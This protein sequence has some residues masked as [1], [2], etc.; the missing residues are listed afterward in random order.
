[1]A[2]V[3]GAY[4][5]MSDF[6]KALKYTYLPRMLS[7]INVARPLLKRIRRDSN[8]ID[9]TGRSS[10]VPVNIL[11]SQALGA[12]ADGGALPAAQ[13]QRYT[14]MI[15][16]HRYNYGRIRL[17]HPTIMASRR[18]STSFI[19]VVSS[20]MDGMRRD[21]MNDINRQLFSDGSGALGFVDGSAGDGVLSI[22]LIAGH[23]CKPNMLVDS[24]TT[25][26]NGAA[27][28][29]NVDSKKIA[30]VSG[31]TITLSAATGDTVDDE[32]W[33]FREDAAGLE[34]M[35][36]LGICDG[37]TSPSYITTLHNIS[38][39]TYPDWGAQVIALG[40]AMTTT[41]M[42]RILMECRA[43]GEGNPTM[44]ITHPTTWRLIGEKLTAV[45]RYTPEQTLHGG[46]Q[47]IDWAGV[48]VF[49]DVQCPKHFAGKDNLF[50]LDES[51][52]ALFQMA[53]WD[54]IDDDGTIL[55]W[56]SGY[57]AFDATLFYYAN[58]GC[59]NPR[60]NGVLRSINTS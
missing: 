34:M 29:L 55:K 37:G 32:S 7:T 58:L 47:V 59:T 5:N 20:E 3:S 36:L 4:Q 22:T 48:P 26:A 33:I 41:A 38:R 57:A 31:T 17:T 42:D 8:K 49:W 2:L 21:M 39:T 40:G 56:I 52:L 19:R 46:F 45:R 30:S 14:E 25:K 13:F 1:M 9:A 10:L 43:T 60:N 6:D 54:W 35:G 50:C 44:M 11:P 15:V 27:G 12:R 24:A 53:D 28:T 23:Y 18:D 16:P 51:T